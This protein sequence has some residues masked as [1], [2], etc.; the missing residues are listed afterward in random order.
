MSINPGHYFVLC[1]GR[2]IK[3]L[4]ELIEI[5]KTIEQKTFEYH[6]N[7]SKND[8]ASWIKYVFK[9][10]HLAETIE[11]YRFNDIRHIIREIKKHLDRKLIL[12]V[13]GGSSSLKFQL[14][15]LVSKNV[16][17]KGM[18]DALNLD[19]CNIK[20]SFNDTDSTTNA[21]VHNHDEAV[22]L[23]IKALLDNEIIGDIAEILAVGHR[24]VHGGEAYTTP[25]VIDDVVISKLKELS[26]LAPLHNPA[27]ISCIIACQKVFKCQ[28]VAVFDTAFHSTI[29]KYKYL[30]GLP[31]KYYAENKIRKY[32]FHGSSHKYISG[33]IT[34]Y[35]RLKHKKNPKVIICHL[36]N[37]SSITAVKNGKSFNTT[38]GFTPLD[39]LIM[40]TR[41]GHL[42]PAVAI[43]I[44]STQAMNYEQ[45]GKMLNKDSGLLGISGHSDMRDLR[46]THNEEKSRLAME[47]FADRIVH[48]IGAYIAELNGVNAIVFTAGIGEN[49][50]YIR[51][52]VL[53]NFKFLGLRLDVKKNQ[54]N[55]FIITRKDSKIECFVIPT[56]EEIQIATE[57]LKLVEKA[58]A[59]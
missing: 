14:I 43:H 13:N 36:G 49:A 22:Q 37:G 42:D 3:D 33:L 55:D 19:R 23:M 30:Y 57:T 54:Q 1:D 32:G 10:R 20:L 21:T 59:S 48:Y 51:K 34:G 31:Y 26:V 16:L 35:Y 56:N 24:V 38:M 39:G 9:S 58:K 41:C 27:N 17:I 46:K 4:K 25:V 5:L 53:E 18:I 6:V 7:D 11:D 29:P 50:Y 45:L 12:V 2:I 15:E 47:M 44:G 40:G 8:F 52:M 28:H